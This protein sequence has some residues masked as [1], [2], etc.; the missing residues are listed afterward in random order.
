MA[1][2]TPPTAPAPQVMAI[3]VRRLWSIPAS[4]MN[5]LC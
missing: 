1:V 2:A 4:L 3:Q 5:F